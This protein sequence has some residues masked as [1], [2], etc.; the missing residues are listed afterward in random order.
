VAINKID[1]QGA[2]PMEIE[3][4]LVSKGKLALE[5]SVKGGNIPVIHIS[6]KNGKNMDLLLELI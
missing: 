3:Q 1:V 2:N 5:G 6:A 4:E